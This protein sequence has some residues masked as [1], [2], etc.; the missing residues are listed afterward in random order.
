[1]G[2][3]WV[4][5]DPAPQLPIVGQAIVA[6]FWPGKFFSIQTLQLDPSSPLHK[7]TRSLQLRVSY[8]DVPPEPPGFVTL[9]RKCDRHGWLKSLDDPP[10]Y[11]R[12]YS[13]LAQA[14]NGHKETVAS[15]SN[16]TLRL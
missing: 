7:L 1:M 10:L 8:D 3:R 4:L 2:A 9:I 6:S 12:E 14:R 16:G 5:E 11:E 15:F 13:N